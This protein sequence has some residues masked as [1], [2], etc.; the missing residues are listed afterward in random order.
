[1]KGRGVFL[2]LSFGL[3]ILLGTSFSGFSQDLSGS[4][5]TD[6]KFN[7]V[8]IPLGERAFVDHVVSYYNGSPAASGPAAD[9]LNSLGR[10]D[11]KKPEDKQ[12]HTSL[13]CGGSII[14]KFEDNALIDIKGA[15]LYVFE[16][17]DTE[18]PTEVYISKTGEVWEKV[19]VIDGG[20]SG[21]DIHDHIPTDGFVQYVKLVDVNTNCGEGNTKGADIDAVAA[22]GSMKISQTA[23]DREV[24]YKDKIQTSESTITIQLWDDLIEDGDTITLKLNDEIIVAHHRVT[25]APETFTIQLTDLDNDII[26]Y[27]E[28]LGSQPPNTAAIRVFYGTEQRKLILSSDMEISQAIKILKR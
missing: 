6:Y 21:I 23:D 20:T 12:K 28:N 2:T 3:L 27:A 13:G 17:G 18:E 7:T 10:P 24:V 14:Y 5:Y 4:F 9:G 22:I 1:M 25:K 26:M 19:G 11:Y 8:Y 16:A 15:D